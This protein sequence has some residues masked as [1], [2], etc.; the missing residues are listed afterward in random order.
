MSSIPSSSLPTHNTITITSKWT[1][2]EPKLDG[3]FDSL[4]STSPSTSYSIFSREGGNQTFWLQFL[5]N[6][7]FMFIAISW[8]DNEAVQ[9]DTLRFY[10]DENH[11][12]ALTD[13]DEDCWFIVRSLNLW[14]LYDRHYESN[15][16]ISDPDNGSIAWSSSPTKIEVKIPIGIN[17]EDHDL[18]ST[19]SGD[20]VGFN[21]IATDSDFVESIPGYSS[22][23][24]EIYGNE[25]EPTT[26]A[27]LELSIQPDLD[28][29]VVLDPSSTMLDIGEVF[30]I[31]CFISNNGNSTGIIYNI[32]VTI[33]LPTGTKLAPTV[34]LSQFKDDLYSASTHGAGYNHTFIW[35]M[36]ANNEGNQIFEVIVDGTGIPRLINE[37]QIEIVTLTTK[38]STSSTSNP[39][40]STTQTEGS[41]STTT[42]SNESTPGFTI[43]NVIIF[44]LTTII[45]SCYSK[46][47][48]RH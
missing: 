42:T 12:G 9:G 5:N 45:F 15:S 26:W 16:W 34:E 14:S 23:T 31:T 4:W 10:F 19:F 3:T 27:N 13:G 28:F 22:S 29:D 18:N 33:S 39:D 30:F 6:E 40:E 48:N 32:N 17:A 37:T 8:S 20:S 24:T 44:F 36:V 25:T 11:D 1:W 2:D 46:K 38:I 21:V 35:T 7:D 47:R 41:S 43:V